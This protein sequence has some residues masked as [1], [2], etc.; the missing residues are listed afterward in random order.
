[1]LASGRFAAADTA[2]L[3]GAL[4]VEELSKGSSRKKARRLYVASLVAPN[5]NAL[6]QAQ[7]AASDLALEGQIPLSWLE[8][9]ASAEAALYRAMSSGDI[10]TGLTK[11]LLW[12]LDEPFASRPLIA[13]SYLASAKGDFHTAT[14]LAQAGLMIEPDNQGLLNNLTFSLLC[15]GRVDAALISL[16]R[17]AKGQGALRDPHTLANFGLLAYLSGDSALGGRAYTEAIRRYE[18]GGKQESANLARIFHA[19]AA[20]A[21]PAA[22]LESLNAQAREAAKNARDLMTKKI[23][24]LLIGLGP[25][26]VG[27]PA[28]GQAGALA[29]K[30]IYDKQ[31]NILLVE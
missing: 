17:A 29:Q 26:D 22:E 4:A 5:D 1:L 25:G 21:I 6:A 20:K 24:M 8:D 18:S 12:H 28:P 19:Y 23:A 13:A 27:L 14:E 2:E 9:R 16:T 11:S 30:W 15:E 7:W 3:A 10:E 31:R